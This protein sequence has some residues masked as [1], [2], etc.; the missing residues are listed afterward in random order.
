LKGVD[1]SR[2]LLFFCSLI[3]R[4]LYL[5]TDIKD[6]HRFSIH[7]LTT[8]TAQTTDV[9]SPDAEDDRRFDVAFNERHCRLNGCLLLNPHQRPVFT[10]QIHVE[11]PRRAVNVSVYNLK[12]DLACTALKVFFEPCAQVRTVS[13]VAGSASDCAPPIGVPRILQ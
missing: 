6:F 11:T 10:A 1:D 8:F 2:C 12:I 7:C 9:S 3:A 13:F 4:F 5:Y